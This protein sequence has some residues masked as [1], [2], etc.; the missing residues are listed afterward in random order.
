MQVDKQRRWSRERERG[1][2]GKRMHVE[3]E[4][5]VLILAASFFFDYALPTQF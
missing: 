1:R 5:F 4:S 3:R 2:K